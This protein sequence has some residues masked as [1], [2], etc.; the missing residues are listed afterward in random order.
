[1]RSDY[2]SFHEL[3]MPDAVHARVGNDYVIADGEFSSFRLAVAVHIH[4]LVHTMCDTHVE[5]VSSYLDAGAALRRG[6]DKKQ[7]AFQ[8]GEHIRHQCFFTVVIDAIQDLAHGQNA[9]SG[10]GTNLANI[11]S[12][13]HL[14]KLPAVGIRMIAHQNLAADNPQNRLENGFIVH[15]AGR[16]FLSAYALPKHHTNQAQLVPLGKYDVLEFQFGAR[17]RFAHVKDFLSHLV[18]VQLHMISSYEIQ[19]L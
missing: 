10:I 5:Q 12:G 18:F 6:G 16:L 9:V 8:L 11:L 1:M 17:N 3:V 15:I 19:K 2:V 4:P 7:V 14:G 13:F